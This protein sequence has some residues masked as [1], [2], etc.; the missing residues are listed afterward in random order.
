[1]LQNGS[2]ASIINY[3]KTPSVPRYA[4][5]SQTNDAYWP[6]G[7]GVDDL[8]TDKHIMTGAGSRE[9]GD[10]LDI[11]NLYAFIRQDIEHQE[12]RMRAMEDRMDKRM[13]QAEKYAKESEDRIDRSMQDMKEQMR[14]VNRA[15]KA[16]YW[17]TTALVIT[18]IGT[19][20][21][22]LVTFLK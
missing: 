3:R 17:A 6:S 15:S 18:V 14:E 22:L 5:F 1:M 12:E 2:V 10:K 20:A 21:T 19:I 11:D 4:N 9:E 8:A 7:G 16:A 13:Q